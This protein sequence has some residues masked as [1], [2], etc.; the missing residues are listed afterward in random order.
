MTDHS[1]L[2]LVYVLACLI[3]IGAGLLLKS[4]GVI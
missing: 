4:W 3:A 1:F 2:L